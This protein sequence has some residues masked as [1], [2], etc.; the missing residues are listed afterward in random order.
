MTATLVGL[1][2]VRDVT[3]TA[4]LEPGVRVCLLAIHCA[5]AGSQRDAGL[6]GEAEPMVTWPA[7]PG[8]NWTTPVSA[9]A[10]QANRTREH[11]LRQRVRCRSECQR[12]RCKRGGG[13]AETGGDGCGRGGGVVVGRRWTSGG[14]RSE[15]WRRRRR[16][17]RR[18]LWWW[19]W[20]WW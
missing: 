15:S 16:R 19:W 12:T 11:E 20:W 13:W 17:R 1:A 7:A 8:Q 4:V 5:L 10:V 14:R 9:H 3:A 18:W 6:A 2:L